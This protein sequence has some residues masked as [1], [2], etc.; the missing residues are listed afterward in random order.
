MLELPLHQKPTDDFF[1][2]N[3]FKVFTIY[4]LLHKHGSYGCNIKFE[5]SAEAYNPSAVILCFYI[6]SKEKLWK[7]AGGTFKLSSSLK[8]FR[9]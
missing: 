1:L 7:V 5:W 3:S 4:S 6:K 8:N 9:G 2:F